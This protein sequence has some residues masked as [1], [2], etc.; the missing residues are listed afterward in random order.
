L[1]ASDSAHTHIPSSTQ[2]KYP[3]LNTHTPRPLFTAALVI[4]GWPHGHQPPLVN[5]DHGGSISQ[6]PNEHNRRIVAAVKSLGIDVWLV[7]E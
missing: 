1:D 2:R 3:D 7:E 4:T 6:K 5:R